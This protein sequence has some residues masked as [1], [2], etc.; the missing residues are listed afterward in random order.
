[1]IRLAEPADLPRLQEIEV[2]A[3]S[4][5]RSLGMDTIADDPAPPLSLFEP[6]LADGRAW[7]WAQRD[8]PAAAFCLVDVVDGGAHVEQVS[9]HPEHGRRG[10]GARLIDHIG[11]WARDRGLP[12]VTLTTFT[13]V[14]WNAPYYTR[15]GFTAVTDDD[16]GPGLQEVRRHETARGLDIAPRIVMTRHVPIDPPRD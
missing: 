6:Y 2:A 7:V 4:L 9:V 5:F 11:E 10:L 12:E 16:L 14:P 3:G 1:M 15:L 8:T 13:D